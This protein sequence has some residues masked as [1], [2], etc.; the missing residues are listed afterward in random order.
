MT[1]KA[2][3]VVLLLPAMAWAT[4]SG[5]SLPPSTISGG[6]NWT[7]VV[8]DT[9][10]VSDNRDCRY[11]NTAQNHLYSTGFGFSVTPAG[12][13]TVDSIKMFYEGQ[14]NSSTAARRIINFRLMKAGTPVGDSVDVTLNNGSDASAWIYPTSQPKWNTTWTEADLESATFGIRIMDA[15]TGTAA[16]LDI[17]CVAIKVWFRDVTSRSQVMRVTIQE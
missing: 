5:D 14:G 17:D 13:F 16:S 2:L 11:S 12:T 4:S 6:T 15:N 9:L 1:T 7:N 8:S 10:E 3:L